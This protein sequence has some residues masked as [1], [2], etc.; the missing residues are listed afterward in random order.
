MSSSFNPETVST[1][2]T[3]LNAHPVYESLHDLNDLRV[4][5]SHHIYSVWDFMSV[6]K[7]LQNRLAPTLVPW[8]PVGDP[9]VRHF[10][11]S[12]VNE[13]ES[14]EGLPDA[15][16]QPTFLSHFELYCL[17]MREI[18]VD[19]DKPLAFVRQVGEQGVRSA[20]AMDGVP[21]ASRRFTST[22][23][24]FIESD[25]PHRVAAALALGREKIIP[26]MFRAFLARMEITERDAPMFLYYL[27]RH[28]HLDEDF[29][30]PL[31]MRLLEELCGG[32][33]Q[34]VAEAE[35]AAQQ[36]LE[37]RIAFWDGVLEAIE[38]ARS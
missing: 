3:R 32:D 38:R 8:V 6:V 12:L 35:Q 27:K 2:Q 36:A 17:A 20:L 15:D 16:G 37:A 11:N 22:T 19:V 28:I 18:G 7:Y 5:M 29:H 26:G 34:K 23:F 1:L 9:A 13:E 4:F 31:S 33:A 10:I 21:E 24:D 25:K 30:G 14:D